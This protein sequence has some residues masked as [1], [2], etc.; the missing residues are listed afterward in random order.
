[1]CWSSSTPTERNRSD[2]PSIAAI[3]S[4][5]ATQ[6]PQHRRQWQLLDRVR[7]IHSKS[8]TQLPQHRRQWQLLDRVRWLERT[9]SG[10]LLPIIGGAAH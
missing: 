8:A 1:M 3:H 10:A 4:K 2:T 9:D 7:A 6:L 5:S